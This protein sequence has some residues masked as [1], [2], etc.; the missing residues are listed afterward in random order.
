MKLSFSFAGFAFVMVGLPLAIWT[1]RRE[2]FVGIGLSIG[3]FVAY[4]M[5]FLLGEALSIKGVLY[6]GLGVWLSNIV[7]LCVGAILI[8]LT[9]KR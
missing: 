2:K 1:R 5:L 3:V 6:P 8:L 7:L 4:Y 9:I